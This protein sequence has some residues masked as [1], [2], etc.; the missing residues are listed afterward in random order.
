MV[1]SGQLCSAQPGVVGA[2][3]LRRAW[4]ALVSAWGIAVGYQGGWK[5]RIAFWRPP[6][7]LLLQGSVLEGGRTVLGLTARYAAS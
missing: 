4:V 6:P 1:S 5:A 2:E 3:A 7:N